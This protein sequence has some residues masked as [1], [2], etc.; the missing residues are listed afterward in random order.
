MTYR[1]AASPAV[2]PVPGELPAD[3]L[4]PTGRVV[5]GGAQQGEVTVVGVQRNDPVPG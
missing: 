4:T 2:N 1:P 3:V 5:L